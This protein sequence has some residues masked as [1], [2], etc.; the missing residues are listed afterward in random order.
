MSC[1]SH[2]LLKIGLLNL[3][4]ELNEGTPSTFLVILLVECSV[5]LFTSFSFLEFLIRLIITKLNE[6]SEIYSE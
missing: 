1:G 2:V 4:L 3:P 5:S 6:R